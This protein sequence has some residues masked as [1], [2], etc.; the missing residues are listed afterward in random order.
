MTQKRAAVIGGGI[1]GLTAALALRR[2]G[3]EAQVFERGAELR[4]VQLGGGLHL[5]TNAMRAL[6]ELG[7]ADRMRDMGS[8]LEETEY[9]SWR[10]RLIARWP[11]GE[12]GREVGIPDVGVSRRD[13]HAVLAEAVGDEAL[14]FG[15][16]MTDFREDGDGVV[17]RFADGREERVDILIGADGI[18][19]TVR[20]Q[21]LGSAPP[22]FAG[23]TQWQTIA[24]ES[25]ALLSAG[26]EYVVFGPGKRAILHHVGGGALFW[27]AVV[28]GPEGAA[29]QRDGRK[30]RLLDQFQGWMEP[31]EKAITATP[32]DDITGFDICDRPPVR[33]WG[34]GRVTL[35]GDAAHPMTTNLSQGA[36]LAME[37]GVVLA[38][39]LDKTADL[40]RALREYERVRIERTTAFVNRSH[41]IAG[42]GAWKQPAVTAVRDRVMSFALGGPDLKHHRQFA[43]SGF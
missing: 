41:R 38:R 28:Y 40:A 2:R 22:R 13:M 21:V 11:I 27:A 23:Y 5:W 29:E 3:I 10:G 19:S 37:D 8:V 1:G 36:C 39:C 25:A 12:I 9:R 26:K 30:A 15:A 6:G 42:M 33:A 14:H 32:E 7:M 18:R 43:A 17:A 34:S 35:L 16:V 4:R 31:L 24:P 20:A